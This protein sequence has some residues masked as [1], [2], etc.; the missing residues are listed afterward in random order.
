MQLEERNRDR[1]DRKNGSNKNWSQVLNGITFA[2][3]VFQ[4]QLTE[5]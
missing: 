2:A 5:G 4:W 1:R 3:T